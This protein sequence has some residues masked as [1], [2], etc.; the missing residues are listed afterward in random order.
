M[1]GDL[2]KDALYTQHILSRRSIS[3]SLI[4]RTYAKRPSPWVYP[5]ERLAN[6]RHR[7]SR[8]DSLAAGVPDCLIISWWQIVFIKTGEAQIRVLLFGFTDGRR[9]FIRRIGY[10]H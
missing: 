7:A 3:Q 8:S 5:G 4:F 10:F 1:A 9:N 2:K 6:T